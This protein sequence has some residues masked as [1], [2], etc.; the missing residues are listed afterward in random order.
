MPTA[1][2]I[3]ELKLTHPTIGEAVFYAKVN[4]DSTHDPGGYRSEDDASM[5]DTGGRMIDKMNKVRWS[6]EITATWDM[7]D[8]EE[9]EKAVQ[10]AASPVLTTCRWTHVSGA[11]YKGKGKPVG[12]L[13]GN[14]N[15]ATFTLKCAGG[16]VVEKIS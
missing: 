4:E 16:G 3:E 5:L 1:G 12:D 6:I 11:T 14:L 15:A 13:Q 8:Q 2:D 7:N 9:L 10:M